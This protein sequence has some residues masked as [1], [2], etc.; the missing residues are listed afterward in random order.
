MM[1]KRVSVVLV[2]GLVSATLLF[3]QN[4][5][6]AQNDEKLAKLLADYL[7]KGRAVI[8]NNQS[9][10]NTS[11]KA[12]KGFT[13][14]VY[15]AQLADDFKKMTGLDI[16]NLNTSD[17]NSGIL[18]KLHNSAKEVVTEA[19]PQIN[20]PGIAFKGFSPA[21]YG[22]KTGD[23]FL[24]KTGITVKQTSLKYRNP[25]NKPDKFETDVL[26]KFENGWVRSKTYSEQTTSGGKKTFRYLAPVYITQMCLTCHGSPA[27]DMD[28]SGRKKEGYKEGDVRGAI[29]VSIPVK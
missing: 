15:E 19:Q 20:Q 4:L 8:A 3:A 18:Q 2:M 10:I 24:K 21:I 1:K 16:K 13:A 25:A 14:A 17:Y 6:A 9:L 28:I 12:D 27:G 5:F 29:S 7:L 22:K 26:K 23:K 11:G